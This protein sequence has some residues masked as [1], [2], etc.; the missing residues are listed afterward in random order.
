MTWHIHY[1]D[2]CNYGYTLKILGALSFL[3]VV[4]CSVRQKMSVAM[5]IIFWLSMEMVFDLNMF[6][7]LIK[8]AHFYKINIIC[9]SFFSTLKV[10]TI[11]SFQIQLQL[12]PVYQ[13][14]T[15]CF[16]WPSTFKRITTRYY[17]KSKLHCNFTRVVHF[18]LLILV[19]LLILNL[20]F[21]K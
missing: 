7:F 6:A 18:I 2:N 13:I 5:E 8:V 4:T 1:H 9:F 21:M 12:G 20:H 14:I 3:S 19:H 11:E 10:R 17:T 16:K 15:T